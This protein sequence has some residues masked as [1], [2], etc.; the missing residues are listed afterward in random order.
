MS[1][2]AIKTKILGN[3]PVKQVGHAADLK[4]IFSDIN[5]ELTIQYFELISLIC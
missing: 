4:K 5:F 3:G 2:G 1:N